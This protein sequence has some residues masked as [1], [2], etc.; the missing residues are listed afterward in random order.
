MR[1]QELLIRKVS[2]GG[3]FP[4]L[5]SIVVIGGKKAHVVCNPVGS[6]LR[7]DLGVAWLENDMMFHSPSCQ[8]K[9]C[10]MFF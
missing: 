4:K 5:P 2:S 6:G 1:S 3:P 9:S 7:N 10:L 8:Q